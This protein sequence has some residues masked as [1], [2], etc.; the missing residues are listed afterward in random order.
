MSL[1]MRPYYNY[2][3]SVLWLLEICGNSAPQNKNIM[4]AKI[5]Y[6]TKNCKYCLFRPASV[7]LMFTECNIAVTVLP[8]LV[9]IYKPY[10]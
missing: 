1:I 8:I 3:V 6:L 2:N 5:D 9:E 7:I 10:M 4:K